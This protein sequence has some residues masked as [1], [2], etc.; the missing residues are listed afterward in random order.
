MKIEDSNVKTRLSHQE[1]IEAVKFEY[2]KFNKIATNLDSRS[3][4]SISLSAALTLLI[5]GF[6]LFLAKDIIDSP[7]RE[8]HKFYL[9][10]IIICIISIILNVLSMILCSHSF[11]PVYYAVENNEIKFV[12]NTKIPSFDVSSK[13]WFEMDEFSIICKILEDTFGQIKIAQR[14]AKLLNIALKLQL[15]GVIT[16]TI[17]T[18]IILLIA[19]FS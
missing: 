17:G 15:L 11:K 10:I 8:L 7:A 4:A 3:N 2:D 5:S 12:K 19:M 13:F 18:I 1:L 14:K 16:F 6:I 9:I